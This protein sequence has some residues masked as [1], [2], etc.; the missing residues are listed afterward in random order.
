[1]LIK[2]SIRNDILI[3]LLG[4][5]LILIIIT[6]SLEIN[7]IITIGNYAQ[8][9]TTVSLNNQTE[10]FLVQLAVLTAEKN[11]IIL[12][13]VRK[14]AGNVAEYVK[15]IFDNTQA[16]AS[17]AHWKFDENVFIGNDGQH[18]NG[19]VDVSSVFIPNYVKID[20]DIKKEIEMG[21]YLDYMSSALLENESNMFAVYFIGLHGELIYYPNKDIGNNVPPDIDFTKEIFFTVANPE[22]DSE[23]KVVWTPLYDDLAGQGLMITASAPIYTKKGFF[24][25]LSID[26]TLNTIS[27]N[28]EKYNPIENSYSF[29]IDKKGRAIALPDKAYNDILGRA[30]K[31]GEY[32]IDLV[33][34][35][36]EFSIIINKMKEGSTGFQSITINNKELYVAY[37][38]LEG[39]GFSL[40]IA[41]EKAIMLKAVSDLQK[42][43]ENST[44]KMIY[45]NTLPTGLLILAIVWIIGLLFIQ[46]IIKPI[47]DLTKTAEEISKGNLNVKVDVKTR[48]EIGQLASSFNKMTK[49]LKRSKKELENYTKELEEKVKKR[50]NQLD[51]K[52]KESEETRIATLNILEDVDET[53]RKLDKTYKELK[54]LDKMK[55]EFMN[56]AAHELKTPL[57]PIIGY[58]DM[59]IRGEMGKINPKEK[60]SLAI[61]LRS[62]QRL[63]KL[64]SD[65]LD[66]SKLETA[67]MKFY[68]DDISLTALIS[69]LVENMMP[70][71]NEKKIKLTSK[72]DKNLPLIKGD[73]SRV[74]EVFENLINNAI[75]FT[76]KGEVFIES[77]I[78]SKNIIISVK[79]SGIGINKEFIKK[80]LF[81]KFQQE[82]S[83][84]RRKYGG[85]GLGL[86][87]CKAIVER[88][89][90]RIWVESEIGKGS[91]FYVSLPIKK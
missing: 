1:M 56:I 28:I 54:K 78:E 11:D 66:I 9:I 7:S 88:H 45:S 73:I 46:R 29:L 26:V 18:L 91:T 30:Q 51:K 19:P 36:N 32:G 58:L 38:P 63:Q 75:K 77:K 2:R 76:E 40:G 86:A 84:E 34:I 15:N 61:A 16:F 35:T 48:N 80:K 85:T 13:A 8:K 27:S 52:I 47:K 33:N 53:R 37:A 31:S 17:D 25:V 82:D 71:A 14:D 22:N 5:V 12:E 3:F 57:V 87:I 62:A 68:I 42:E 64:V 6:A 55:A 67:A 41:V 89:K 81:K 21:T 70:F 43:M 24:G 69:N 59:I 74:T 44:Q 72:I 10:K 65:I 23:R 49:D 39:T 50:T 20:D 83:T 90:G 79:D 60:E 4:I